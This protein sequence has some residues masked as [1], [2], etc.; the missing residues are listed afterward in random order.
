[1]AVPV[2]KEQANRDV[3]VI[4]VPVEKPAMTQEEWRAFILSTAGSIDVRR[5][6]AANK[7]NMS[8]ARSYLDASA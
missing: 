6:C 4:I 5:S 2:G 7:A 1:M 3:E 8:D